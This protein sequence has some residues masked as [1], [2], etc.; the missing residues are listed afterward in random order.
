[1][2]RKQLR[3]IEKYPA[4]GIAHRDDPSDIPQHYFH[5]VI[6]YEDRAAMSDDNSLHNEDAR[7]VITTN[8]FVSAQRM[9]HDDLPDG[10][11]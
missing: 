4:I 11:D 10:E 2:L 1:M 8:Q 9:N 5:I 3:F 7:P 6:K